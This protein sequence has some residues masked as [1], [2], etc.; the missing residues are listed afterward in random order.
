MGW[1]KDIGRI[2]QG[3]TATPAEK[4]L[5]GRVDDVVGWDH[6]PEPVKPGTAYMQFWLQEMWL[7]DERSWLDHFAPLVYSV[8]K[9]RFGDEEVEIPATLGDFRFAGSDDLRHLQGTLRANY[10]MTPPL[11]YNGGVV[12][13][14]AAL[15]GVQ[16]QNGLKEMITAMDQLAKVLA[17]PQLSAVVGVAGP[18][19]NTLDSV[20]GHGQQELALGVH[21][22]FNHGGT[23]Q[24]RSGYYLAARHDG[25]P[26]ALDHFTV[27]DGA[28]CWKR[29]GF[30]LV[31]EFDYMLFRLELLPE[32]DDLEYVASI[33]DWMGKAEEAAVAEH[34]DD[35]RQFLRQASLAAWK[36][37]DLTAAD[38][39]RVPAALQA[40]FIEFLQAMGIAGDGASVN[41]EPAKVVE[42]VAR[43]SP[44]EAL[45]Q[46]DADVLAKILAF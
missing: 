36:S 18:V 19:A 38:R 22:A 32:R 40:R 16:T 3:E 1:L 46:P 31:R 8:V 25:G 45:N 30:P 13:L 4:L 27:R 41:D 28:L 9:L 7:Q 37:L 42:L 14:S 2:L 26:E 6:D 33:F 11:P 23:D 12:E 43:T 17:V 20:L 5:Y 35:A 15:V 10:P 34:M 24:L 44:D 21:Q 39:R 29:D